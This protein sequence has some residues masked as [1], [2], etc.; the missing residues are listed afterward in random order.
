VLN[1]TDDGIKFID[2]WSV[3]RRITRRYAW[4]RCNSFLDD[5]CAAEG[6]A[7]FQQFQDQID[8]LRLQNT[9]PQSIVATQHFHYLPPVGL[10]PM[11]INTS[12]Y[13]FDYLQFFSALTY[14]NPVYIE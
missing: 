3:R 1:W 4:E 10:L 11:A 14:R 8:T 7:K 12:P 5:R 13:G 9:N 2:M 6:E